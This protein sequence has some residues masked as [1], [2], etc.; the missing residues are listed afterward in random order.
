MNRDKLVS[1]VV[2]NFTHS[3]DAAHLARV[4]NA[5]AEQDIE[6]L[7]VHDSF[8]CLAPQ[9]QR[10]NQIIRVELAM[11]YSTFDPLASLRR[12]NVEGDALPLPGRGSHD[13]RDVQNAEYCF[14]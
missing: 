13:P 2:A 1:S 3:M 4:V 9:A 12:L 8:S 11:M 6:V 14:A 7:T 10:L 5:A